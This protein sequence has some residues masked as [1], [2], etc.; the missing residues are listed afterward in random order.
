L[1]NDPFRQ[2]WLALVANP[3]DNLSDVRVGGNL[4]ESAVDRQNSQTGFL[5]RR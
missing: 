3:L 1:T 4:F 5:Y 2:A